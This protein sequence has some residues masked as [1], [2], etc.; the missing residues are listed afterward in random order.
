MS[1]STADYLVVVG[2]YPVWSVCEHG[3][4]TLLVDRL[5]PLLEQ[6][7]ATTYLAGHD[8]CA[9]YIN[10]GTGVQYHGI[11][12]S[13]GCDASTAHTGSVPSVLH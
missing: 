6:Y 7:K 1:A 12:A 4:T 3:P 11:G 13:H 10:E 9:E 2:H 8:H 5:K